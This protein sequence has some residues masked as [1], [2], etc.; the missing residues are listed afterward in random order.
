MKISLPPVK[1]N[2]DESFSND[3]D[4]FRRKDFGE[5]LI[6]LFENT[7]EELVV[8]LNAPW[9]EGKSTFIK[10]WQNHIKLNHEEKKIK[11]IYFDAFKNDYQKDPF[12]AITS[13]IYSLCDMKEESKKDF[14]ENAKNVGKSLAWGAFKLGT[15]LT[16]AGLVDE[17]ILESGASDISAI[18]NDNIEKLIENRIKNHELNKNVLD[19]FKSDLEKFIDNEK[20]LVFIIDELDRCRPDYALEL[21]E[22]IKHLF[23]VKNLHFLLVVNSKQF[24]A[25]IKSKY[26]NDIN[27][28]QYLQKFITL[29]LELPKKLTY[30]DNYNKTFMKWAIKEMLEKDESIKNENLIKTIE[31]ISKFYNTSFREIERIL[32]NIAILHN[33]SPN[34]KYYLSYQLIIAFI[35]YVKVANP[36]VFKLLKNK[37]SNP[38]EIF[39]KL[40]LDKIPEDNLYSEYYF[41]GLIKLL[42]IFDYANTQKRKEL[43]EKDNTYKEIFERGYP[44]NGNES[45]LFKEIIEDLSSLS[46]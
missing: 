45:S 19:K 4:I 33:M 6:S 21:L 15:K 8:A 20:P 32:S 38:Q 43:L 10:M 24:E 31:E 18:L 26:G 17:T 5:R 3:K 28:S 35:C 30:Y 16:T 1:I 36:E 14:I 23:S 41:L 27:A 2:D 39:K 37:K 25:S 13:E 42:L 22:Q 40:E 12:L 34:T 46:R 44:Y 7:Q 29:T 9:G 11:T